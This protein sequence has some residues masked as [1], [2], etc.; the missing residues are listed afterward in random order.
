MHVVFDPS[1]EASK[2][3]EFSDF[4]KIDIRIGMVIEATEFP[5]A[6]NPSYILKIDFGPGVGIKKSSA[7]ITKHYS[8]SGLVGKRVAAVVNFLPRQIGKVMSEVLV[9]GFSDANQD[10]VLFSPDLDVPLGARLH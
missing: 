10:V 5:E 8:L 1:S 6:K 9:L 2:T 7:Q 4:L 3:I